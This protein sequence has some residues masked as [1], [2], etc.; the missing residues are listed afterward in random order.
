MRERRVTFKSVP[1]LLNLYEISD[2]G[3]VLRD[4]ETKKQVR[5]YDGNYIWCYIRDVRLAGLQ[6][7]KF[8]MHDK[9][10]RITVYVHQLVAGAWIGE[11]P[12]GMVVDHIGRNRKN[13]HFTNL[14]FLTYLGNW[15]NQEEEKKEE[16][17]AMRRSM[18]YGR[19]K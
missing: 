14:R 12:Q 6:K 17:R 10:P 9:K 5:F 18:K 13:N 1:S 15:D 4:C 16:L 19:A 8:S 2:C 11:K 3:T 7:A